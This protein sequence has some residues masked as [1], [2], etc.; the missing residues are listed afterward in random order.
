MR[1]YSEKRNASI[2]HKTR[3]LPII[4]LHQGVNF[5]IRVHNYTKSRGP[6]SGK[7]HHCQTAK[8]VN[9]LHASCQSPQNINRMLVTMLICIQKKN[10]TRHDCYLQFPRF[11]LGTTRNM[12]DY[13]G[14]LGMDRRN[15][16]RLHF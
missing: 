16:K 14:T 12:A 5:S 9:N 1:Q 15:K 3:F 4:F 7:L 10:E 11:R 6:E 8:N 2:H 13:L